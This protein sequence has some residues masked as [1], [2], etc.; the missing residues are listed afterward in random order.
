MLTGHT[1]ARL[2]CV[3]AFAASGARRH[4]GALHAAVA[5]KQTQLT[6]ETDWI[7]RILGDKQSKRNV[8]RHGVKT[9]H[10]LTGHGLGVCGCTFSPDGT[11]LA[12][13]IR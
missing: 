10:T 13:R 3:R 2:S 12:N 7:D 5:A 1:D 8:V 6:W 9:L 11:L 4:F